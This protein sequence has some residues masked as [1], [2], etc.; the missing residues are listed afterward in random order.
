MGECPVVEVVMQGTVV[1]CLLDTGSMVT[2]LTAE[3]F[4]KHFQSLSGQ[5]QECRWLQLRAANGLQIP[6]LGYL[7]VD[8]HI[9]G[10]TLPK[11]G[12]LVVQDSTDPYTK[13]QKSKV[14]GL[15]GMNV[16]NQC[17]DALFQQHG[18]GL[19]QAPTVQ[20]AGDAWKQAFTE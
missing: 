7:E 9:L 16:I 19:F 11:M 6:Y 8:L 12:V 15:L 20:V 3:F 10:R 18:S 1:P 2:T 17:Y 13:T 14:P 4:Y 5:L